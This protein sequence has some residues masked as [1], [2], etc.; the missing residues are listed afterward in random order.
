[1]TLYVINYTIEDTGLPIQRSSP[2]TFCEMDQFTVTNNLS[3]CVWVFMIIL[4]TSSAP[5]SRKLLWKEV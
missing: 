1:M 3:F 2:D 4:Y 5:R